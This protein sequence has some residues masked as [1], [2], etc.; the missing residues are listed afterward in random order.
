MI[1]ENLFDKIGFTDVMIKEY[2]KHKNL[3][4]DKFEVLAKETV[5]NNIS[6]LESCLK[7]RSIVPSVSKY[8]IDLMFI[9]ECT[10]YLL[11]KYRENNIPDD[12]FYNSML[13]IYCKTQECIKVKNV[14]GIFVA[15]WFDGFFKLKRFAFGRLQYDI[16]RHNKEDLVIGNRIIQNGDLV[17][18][19]HISSLG[20]L[21]HEQCIE[22]Y[23]MAYGYF[24]NELKDGILIIQ[25]D[26][27]FLMPDYMDILKGSSPNIYKFA[28]DYKIF[29]VNYSDEFKIGWRIFG[30]DVDGRNTE[31]LPQN[32]RLQRGFIDHINSGGK[33]GSGKGVLFFDGFNI[34][35]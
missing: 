10:G 31:N 30:V 14:F 25:C 18:W 17:L 7:A 16:T 29:G 12:M 19:C 1:A 33:F 3:I 4:D 11:I 26:S 24:R 35:E 34:S 9:L 8:T 2:E 27:W 20:P 28:K 22:S 5:F 15:E 21:L 6:M 13:D 32:T 23:K